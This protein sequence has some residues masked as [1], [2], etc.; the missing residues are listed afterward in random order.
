[1]H[2]RLSVVCAEDVPFVQRAYRDGS[3]GYILSLSDLPVLYPYSVTAELLHIIHRRCAGRILRD[4]ITN[5]RGGLHCF[6]ISKARLD[7]EDV[8]D[9]SLR[10]YYPAADLVFHRMELGRL[11]IYE[12][13]ESTS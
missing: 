9:E 11:P 6:C 7:G 12:D 3:V 10:R 13:R 4:C 5:L 1:M 2:S 8:T